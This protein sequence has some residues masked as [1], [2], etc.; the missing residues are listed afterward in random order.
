MIVTTPATRPV[1]LRTQSHDPTTADAWPIAAGTLPFPAVSPRGPVR[2]LG[3]PEWGR[4]FAEIATA[5]FDHV[6]LTDTW[7]RPAE[8]TGPELDALGAAA[9]DAGLRIPAVGLIRRSVIAA[10]R[11]GDAG[12][13]NLRYSHVSLEAAA[14]LG[15]RVVSVGLHEALH[16]AQREV[17]WFW[18]RPGARNDLADVE[19]RRLAVSRLRELGRHAA[20]LGLLL[21]LEMYEDTFLGTAAS[22]VRLVEE[23][24][25]PNV[26]LNPDTGNLI[27]LHR[28]I[29]PWDEVLAAVLPYTNYWHVKNYFR[30]EDPD[31][32][33]VFTVP[34]SLELGLINYRWAVREALGVGFAGVLTCE[35][36]GGDGLS[37]SASNRDYLRAVL[38]PAI[39]ERAR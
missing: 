12:T 28:P 35:H 10:D 18:T 34:T 1:P 29:E 9:R 22:S 17:L 8:L 21:S 6:E 20:E 16:A 15:A 14:A 30:D 23:I 31:S 37:V 32:D 7:L 19:R 25:L 11:G 4:T 26:G 27:R 38:R 13:A 3:A 24:G 2:E 36:Y 5:G 33:Q 39:G